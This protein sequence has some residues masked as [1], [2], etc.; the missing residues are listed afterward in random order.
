[1]TRNLLLLLLLSLLSVSLIAAAAEHDDHKDD[2]QQKQQNMIQSEKFF[3]FDVTCQF[4]DFDM[5]AFYRET[6]IVYKDNQQED[7]KE[8][9][10]DSHSSGGVYDVPVDADAEKMK[11]QRDLL[12]ESTFFLPTEEADRARFEKDESYS[13]GG[14]SGSFREGLEGNELDHARA[15]EDFMKQVE[16]AKFNYDPLRGWLVI[17]ELKKE[18]EVPIVP[19]EPEEPEEPEATTETAAVAKKV[20][21]M[22][23]IFPHLEYADG[24]LVARLADDKLKLIGGVEPNPKLTIRSPLFDIF[25]NKKYGYDTSYG[26]GVTIFKKTVADITTEASLIFGKIQLMSGAGQCEVRRTLVDQFANEFKQLNAV[27]IRSD[28]FP[29]VIVEA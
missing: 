22:Q 28:L 26:K 1:M 5:S 19:E 11:F 17:S 14:V 18:V 4:E 25:K 10:H 24:V 21:N 23:E 27:E 6:E 9:G 7:N 15:Q 2:Q 13:S 16:N 3:R 20:I 8:H 12:V 29:S